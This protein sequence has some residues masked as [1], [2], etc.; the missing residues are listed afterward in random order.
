MGSAFFFGMLTFT[1]GRDKCML[2]VV[3]SNVR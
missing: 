2:E 3:C 1:F